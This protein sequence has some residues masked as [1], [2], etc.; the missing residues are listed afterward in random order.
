[1]NKYLLTDLNGNKVIAQPNGVEKLW[2]IN[3]GVIIEPVEVLDEH[4][5][6]R[7]WFQHSLTVQLNMGGNNA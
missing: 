6:V 5:D 3:N 7:D 1:M 2:L 4:D